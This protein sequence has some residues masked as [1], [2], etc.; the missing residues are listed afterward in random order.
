M[1]AGR[2]GAFLYVKHVNDN[3]KRTDSID[4]MVGGNRPTKTVD[5]ALNILLLGSDSRDPDAPVD[6]GGNW[7]TDTIELMHIPASHDKAY[8]VSFP[9]DLWVHIPQSKSSPYGNTD[10]KINAASAWGGVPLIVETVEQYT[11]VRID[12]LALIDFAGFVQVVDALGGVDL[13]ID[14]TITSIHSPYRTFAKGTH[15]FNGAEALDCVRQRKQ[16]AGRRLRPDPPPAGVPQ[17]DHGQGDQRR[18]G[19]QP[20]HADLVRVV[21]LQRVTVD[22]DF[23]LLDLAWQLHNLKSSD[24]TFMTCP[25]NGTGTVDDQSVVLTN[26]PKATSLF[27]AINDD[28][29]AQWL[30]Q[31]G[32]AN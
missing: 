2:C 16:F 8:L 9:R 6:V 11:G 19:H 1:V 7:R 12:H 18:D 10:A 15:H 31:P 28:T 24:L 17:S 21:G 30:T 20:G 27:K 23:S 25:N 14:Q 26:P 13:Y 22:K 29:V 5:G 3:L 32:N 4:N